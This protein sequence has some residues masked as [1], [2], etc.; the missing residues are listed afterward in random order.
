MESL[1][2]KNSRP[3]LVSVSEAKLSP[4]HSPGQYLTLGMEADLRTAVTPLVVIQLLLSLQIPWV[5]VSPKLALPKYKCHIIALRVMLPE[6]QP[7]PALRYGSCTPTFTL[8]MFLFNHLFPNTLCSSGPSIFSKFMG[9]FKRCRTD[10][11]LFHSK[12]TC[13]IWLLQLCYFTSI[14]S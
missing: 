7:Q 9:E 2:V 13:K 10:S 6:P 8:H 4:F 1:S 11:G 5:G 14:T 3:S 12:N